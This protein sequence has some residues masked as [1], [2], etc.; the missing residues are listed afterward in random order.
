ME[1]LSI[2]TQESIKISLI[3]AAIEEVGRI[4]TNTEFYYGASASALLAGN[5]GIYTGKSLNITCGLGFCGEQAAIMKML[6]D[7]ETRIEMIVAV[8]DVVGVIAPCGKCREMMAQIDIENMKT[9][10]ILPSG[11]IVALKELLPHAWQIE[12]LDG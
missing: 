2:E 3:N 7:N 6:S 9:E 8:N 10:V 12:T 4:E 1:K 5:G 11:E